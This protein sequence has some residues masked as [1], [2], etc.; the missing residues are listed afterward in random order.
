MS[1]KIILRGLETNDYIHHEEKKFR[2]DALKNFTLVQKGLDMLNDGSVQLLRQITEGKWVEVTRQTAPDLFDVLDEVKEVLDFPH[3]PKIFVRHEWT[4][5]ISC[6]GT[7][8]MQILLPDAVLNNFDRQMLTF[9]LG[10]GIGM[11]K[12]GN[13]R[14][15]TICSV[16]IDNAATRPF[17]LALH[18]YIRAANLSNER[19]GLLACQDIAAAVKCLLCEA[20]FPLVELRC[21]SDEEILTFAKNYPDAMDYMQSDFLTDTAA[22]WTNLNSAISPVYLRVQELLNWYNDGGYDAVLTKRGGELS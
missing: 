18:V 7:D 20:G 6:G 4:F 14:L 16:L 10:R 3:T 12:S 9:M 2:A 5:D 21:L 22:F 17:Q 15:N 19:A 8:Y 11:F 13:V 1:D